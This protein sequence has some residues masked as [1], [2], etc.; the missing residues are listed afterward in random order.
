L[1][2]CAWAGAGSCEDPTAMTGSGS[3]EPS[4]ADALREATDSLRESEERFRT[5]AGQVARL[6][7][8]GRRKD[9]FLATLAHELRNPLA[10]IVNGLELLRAGG[11]DPALRAR[12]L[13][14]LERQTAHLVRLI[15]DLLDVSR[16]TRGKV[17]LRTREVELASVIASA[18]EA[19]RPRLD[20]AGHELA[21]DLP[22]E[23]VPLRADPARLAQVFSNLLDNAAKYTPPG[24]RVGLAAE[25]DGGEVE[26]RVTD[27]GPGLEPELRDRIFE[28][29]VQGPNDAVGRGGLGVGLTVVR[30]LVELHGGR[31][32]AESGGPGRGSTFTV[33]LPVSNRAAAEAPARP[34]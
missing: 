28:M 33:R 12:V 13:E 18:I 17:E 9:E 16:I 5:L 11:D 1:P 2:D 8:A 21:V 6:R 29:F 4:G 34:A 14:I 30:S 25:L 22:G 32:A 20:G 24:G 15:D 10:P 7:E 3:S 26:V 31:V 23:P 19:S 27:T